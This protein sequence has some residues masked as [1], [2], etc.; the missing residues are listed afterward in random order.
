LTGAEALVRALEEAGVEVVFG[1]PGVH[2][3][4]IWKALGSSP[5]RL[6]TVRHEETAAYAADGYAR[7]TGRLGVAIVTTGPGA[8]NTLAAVGEAW[9]SHS[10]V[11][12]VATD[13]PTTIRREGVH[14]GALHECA[15]QTGMFRPVTRHQERAT[16]AHDF[17]GAIGAALFEATLP[18]TRPVYLE[19]PTDLLNAEVHQG[20]RGWGAFGETARTEELPSRLAESE[21]PLIWA[22][23]GARDAAAEVTR[24]AERLG[25]PVL[26]THSARGVV[27]P[28]RA[29][30]APHVREV[31]ELWDQA[32][33]VLVLG[34]DLDGVNTQNWTQPQP[35]TLISVNLDATEATKNYT[36]D[37]V[38][39]ADVESVLRQV[40]V[41]Q[42]EPWVD[43]DAVRAAIRERL[44]EEHPAEV[45]FLDAFAEAVPSDAVVVCDMCIPGYWLTAFY[46]PAK[47]RQLLTPFGWGT[48]GF[49][50]P[51]SIGATV[52]EQG[53]VVSVCGDG[54]ILF[55]VGELATVVEEELPLT[56]VIVD[57]GGY[58]MLRYDQRRAG[59]TPHGVDLRGP[60]FVAL[61]KSF[62]IEA[63]VV[64]GLA[65]RFAER[66]AEHVATD[67][68][69]V[70]VARAA[71][72]P[73][74][75]T[76]PR[77]P[78]REAG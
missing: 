39:E 5:I 40:D 23:G 57:D 34:S 75:T 4:A 46:T 45:A 67:E 64:G 18:P 70:L 26:T 3:L 68:P 24:L 14:R 59:E 77:W 16:S 27:P 49:G 41:E 60:D 38:V 19:L 20:S 28:D 33:L 11:L 37:V 7:A 42:R 71:L 74:E 66:L 17:R 58:G 78:R 56:L 13:I 21:R 15:D 25:A 2:N 51:A 22:G 6:V 30:P 53:P 8:A 29:L 63:E 48:L 55:G 69:T 61:A 44:T 35:P 36:P 72:E 52:A 73:P 65:E 47:P 10:P 31:G 76:S 54:G 43:L 32:D 9:A 12:V 62:R 50:F 1:L